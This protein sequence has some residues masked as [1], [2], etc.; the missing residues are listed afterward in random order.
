MCSSSKGMLRGAS[1]PAKTALLVA[2]ALV[3]L[4]AGICIGSVPVPPADVLRILSN[5]LWGT[6]LPQSLDAMT[7]GIVWSIRLPRVLMAFF[8]GA[9][10]AV[11]GAVMQSVLRNPLASSFGLGVSSGAGLGAAVVIVLGLSGGLLGSFLLPAVCLV[12]GFGAVALAMGLAARIDRGL[13]NHTIILTGMVLSLFLN[14]LMTTLAASSPEHTH[15]LMQWQLGSFSLREWR[16]LGPVAVLVPLCV[17]FF[18]LLYREL[19]LMSF[20]E[21]QAAAM[22]VELRR[23][24]W[25]L[26]G[27]VSLLTGVCVAFVG[28]I[29][30]VDLIAPHIAR[31]FFGPGH[32]RLIPMSAVF[33]GTFM[34]LCDLAARTLASPREIPIGSITALL[35]APFFLYVF[36]AGRRGE[37]GC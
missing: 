27:G 1:L 29:G 20:G 24:K 2:A 36:L 9:G 26:I 13:S 16:H 11:S 8:V 7:P 22:G 28:I 33:G 25:L 19:D 5:R 37:R 3:S 15:Q 12:C 30:F 32:G 6:P 10:L 21:E 34:V 31:R 14:A 35:G 4:L 17:G 18:C 23:T